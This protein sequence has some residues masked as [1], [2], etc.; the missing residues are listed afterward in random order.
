MDDHAKLVAF[1]KDYVKERKHSKR[2]V[3]RGV[4]INADIKYILETYKNPPKPPTKVKKNA[5]SN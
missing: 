1:L 3:T 4:Q 2:S 5:A